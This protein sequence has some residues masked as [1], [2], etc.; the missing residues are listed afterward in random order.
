MQILNLNFHFVIESA[1]LGHTTRAFLAIHC[2]QVVD[3]SLLSTEQFKLGEQS[4]V[5][6]EETNS[7][8]SSDCLHRKRRETEK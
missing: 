3:R 1:P 2:P 6:A 4:R 8:V 5:C 7:K